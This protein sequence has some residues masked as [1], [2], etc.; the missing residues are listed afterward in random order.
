M[1]GWSLLLLLIVSPA[2][3]QMAPVSFG[4][5]LDIYVSEL[6]GYQFGAAPYCMADGSERFLA[7]VKRRLHIITT[8]LVAQKGQ[9]IVIRAK[10]AAEKEFQEELASV[11]FTGCKIGDPA[12][13]RKELRALKEF[14]LPNLKSLEQTLSLA[15]KR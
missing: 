12:F 9:D 1:R 2:K 8:A 13:D 3:G 10:K 14:H 15:G 11:Y 5:P 6:V 4:E 7:K